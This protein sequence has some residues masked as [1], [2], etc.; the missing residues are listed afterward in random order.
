[1]K[2]FLSIILST[3]ILIPI[4]CSVVFAASYY[5]SYRAEVDKLNGMDIPTQKQAHRMENSSG[6]C[7]VVAAT[8]L[9]NRRVA[10]DLGNNYNFSLICNYSVWQYGSSSRCSEKWFKPYLV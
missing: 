5:N 9:L 7:N 4:L 1:M 6:I 8:Q 2:R 10:Y 3:I